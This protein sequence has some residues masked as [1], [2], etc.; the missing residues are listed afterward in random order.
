M[1]VLEIV[2]AALFG[3]ALGSFVNVCISRLPAHRSIVRPASRCPHCNTPIAMR[4]NIPLLSF[5]LL[6]GRCR[7]CQRHISWRYPLIELAIAGLTVACILFFDLSLDGVAG[8]V[9]CAFMVAL[10]VCDAETLRLP[11]ALTMPLI[12]LGILY[13]FSDGLTQRLHHSGREGLRYGLTLG[14]R[15]AISAVATA[16]ALLLLR[17]LYVLLRKRQG[18]GLGD[19][20]LAAGIA[21]WLGARQMLVVFFV[22]VVSGALVTLTLLA[23]TRNK[24][25]SG[26]G[27]RAVPFGTF[28]ALAAIY[29][30]F[31]GWS[32][33]FWYMHFF[34]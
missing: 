2:F 6:R 22:A 29:G 5:A 14:L 11:D 21:A 13:R 18:M 16:L 31:F 3:L 33:L 4:D 17:W 27:P 10:A 32:T 1:I 24:A 12:G 25:R 20:K 9:F 34:A 23:L 8:A 7:S 19:V 26:T 15:G 28:L 30:L